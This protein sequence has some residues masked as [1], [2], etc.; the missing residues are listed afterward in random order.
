MDGQHSCGNHDN[1]GTDGRLR[2][3][4]GSKESDHEGWNS[5]SG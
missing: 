5:G 4:L 3:T 1:I 2:R